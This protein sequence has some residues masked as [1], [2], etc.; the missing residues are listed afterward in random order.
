[1]TLKEMPL[2]LHSTLCIAGLALGVALHLAWHPLRRHFS[3]AYDFVRTRRL[4][5]WI[6]F[7]ALALNEWLAPDA[8]LSGAGNA[9][10]D[11]SVWPGG[12]IT[13]LKASALD[14]V[15][16]LHQAIPI[17]PLA[18]LL[19]LWMVGLTVQMMRYP[20]RYQKEKLHAPQKIIL[21]FLAALSLVWSVVFC[22]TRGGQG[23]DVL[24]AV[25]QPATL[26]FSS[27]A[28]AGYQ[29]WL[30]RLVIQWADP[31]DEETSARDECF[32]RWQN[33]LWL[34]GF[35]AVWLALKVWIGPSASWLS[36]SLLLEVLFVFAPL[37]VA[38]AAGRGSLA[39]AGGLA[40]RTLWR[41]GLPLL[42]WAVTAVALL[43]LGRYAVETS[44]PYGRPVTLSV[45]VLVTGMLHAWLLPTAM[46]LL[47]RRAFPSQDQPAY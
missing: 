40:L 19:P 6:T 33:V 34:G 7:A 47:Y 14:A 2:W 17:M 13:L 32:A 16:L 24:D 26:F 31:S 41:G 27:L 45:H 25:M 39:K 43:A 46:L 44:L 12:W 30:A 8:S 37:P 15:V 4:P 20:Y 21:L 28:T 3:D 9:L 38:I 22:F 18:V 42:A 10:H 1:M 36:W 29:V 35:N 23:Q 11:F 5:L